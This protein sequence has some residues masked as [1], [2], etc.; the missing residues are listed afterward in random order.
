MTKAYKKFN[1]FVIKKEEK[2]YGSDDFIEKTNQLLSQN[3]K[4][5]HASELTNSKKK[6][7][8]QKS[9]L[10]IPEKKKKEYKR[11]PRNKK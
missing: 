1:D 8:I 4:L 9:N 5:F 11:T 10:G 6:S 7:K 3:S 2:K